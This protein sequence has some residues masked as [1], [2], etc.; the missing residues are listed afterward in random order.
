M[1]AVHAWDQPDIHLHV[2]S[3]YYRYADPADLFQK[4]LKH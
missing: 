1:D 4:T 2:H 3:G